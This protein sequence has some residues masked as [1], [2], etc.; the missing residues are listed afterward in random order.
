MTR[1]AGPLSVPEADGLRDSLRRAY[2]ACRADT[3][4]LAAD[5]TPEDQTVQTMTDASPAKWHRAHVTWFFEA[6][7]LAQY[8]TGYTPY[9]EGFFYLFNSYYEALGAKY[10]RPQRGLVSRPTVETIAAYRA[11]VDDAMDRFMAEAEPETWAAAAP[12]VELGI[13]H[14]EQHQELLLTDILHVFAH[15]PLWPAFRPP[16]PAPDRPAPAR[17]WVDHPGGTVEIGARADAFAYDNEEPRHEVRLYP[18]RLADRLVTNGEWLAFMADDGYRRPEFWLSDGWAA[19]NREDWA[20]PLYWHKVDGRWH[21][22]TLGGLLPVDEHAPVCHV[23]H[24]EADAFAAWAGR[25]L[26]SEA[27]WEVFAADHAPRGN[28]AGTGWLRPVAADPAAPAP[29]QLYGDVWEWTRSPYGP[30][31]GYRPPAGAIG[32]YNGKFMANQMVLRGGSAV[33]PD[34][35][36][37]ATYRNFFYPHQRWQFMGLRLA[38]DAG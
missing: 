7:I 2:A 12:L 15:N 29:R 4:S 16:V 19:A 10:P 18:F 1:Y 36:A 17:G 23:S 21:Q 24:Y 13:A 20:A 8:A 38:E 28:T 26:P 5:L 34:G 33:T 30:Y 27:E 14:E 35:H 31:P 9:D 37:R 25:R 6:V 32:E 3:E 11:H 22:M